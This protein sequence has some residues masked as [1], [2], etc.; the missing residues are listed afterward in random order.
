[1]RYFTRIGAWAAAGLLASGM[2]VGDEKGLLEDV[3]TV[4]GLS[5][6]AAA[7]QLPLKLRGVVTMAFPTE[8]GSFVIDDGRAG[9]FVRRY[10]QEDGEG[11]GEVVLR[12]GDV[13]ELE[14]T[15]MEGGFARDV[16]PNVVRVMGRGGLP[17]AK[18][19]T[20]DNLLDGHL[21]CQRVK[22]SG[23]VR[24]VERRE[25]FPRM[26]L[27]LGMGGGRTLPLMLMDAGED[28]ARR[29]LDAEVEAVG[30]AT[31]FFNERGELIGV[32]VQ[33]PE[34]DGVLVRSAAVEK[35]EVPL[36][37]LDGLNQ[38]S[39]D[40]P[41]FKRTKV[42]GTVTFS[43]KG[44]FFYVQEGS[45]AVRVESRGGAVPEPGDR[46]EVVGY[47]EV[48]NYFTE[49]TAAEVKVIG[50]V[51]LPR[52][53]ESTRE[54]ILKR[55]QPTELPGGLDGRRVKIRAWLDKVESSPG[56]GR[57]LFLN[58]EGV[59]V[60][61][62]LPVGEG[63]T[64]VPG[65]ELEVIGTCVV[66]LNTKWPAVNWPIPE[67]FHLL[68]QSARDIT[69][70]RAAPWWT[71]GRIWTAL[72]VAALSAAAGACW[73]TVLR[74]QVG[75]QT[76]TI[77]MQSA[78]ET[79]AEER[80][81]LAR[82]FHDTLEQELTGLSI[83]LD[84]ASDSLPEAPEQAVRALENAHT[85]LNYTRT[86]ARRSIWDLR[87]MALQEHGLCGALGLVVESLRSAAGP[88][89]VLGCGGR[90]RRL[91]ARLETN[92]LRIGTECVTNAFKHAEATKVE[93]TLRFGGAEVEL[94]VADDGRGFDPPEAGEPVSGHFG[95]RGMRERAIQIGAS[96]RVESRPGRGA[97]VVVNAPIRTDD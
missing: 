36:Q 91:G 73:V 13:V 83:Q 95:L 5:R 88:E 75:M 31:S 12:V 64:L 61:A 63:T 10:P 57:R 68:V 53:L 17:E 76:E 49:L 92:L 7:R 2:A 21:D 81:R 47:P 25:N 23:V 79:L 18:A 43:R 96:L 1:M 70:A 90:E 71:P 56:G 32:T 38:F 15:T 46:V 62:G 37:E 40:P 48:R 4:R 24:F 59:T 86:E 42:R 87:S 89:I 97:R 84:A 27:V 65:S 33:V 11:G 94:S 67:S 8:T 58:H 28:E 3:M 30:V 60:F 34:A 85:L 77:R 39:P 29:F 72:S 9:I 14:G 74:R 35:G 66:E 16:K 78:R 44:E 52:A 50:K 19:A 55:W 45:R 69:V 54:S 93:V 51:E 80:S 6:E 22:I 82:E 41:S 20:L 26:K